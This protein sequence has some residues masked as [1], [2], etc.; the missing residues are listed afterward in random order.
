MRLRDETDLETL[1]DELVGV[2]SETMQ[3]V[4]VSLWLRSDHD[5]KSQQ[6]N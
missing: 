5:P 4:H 6:A 3:P 2:V 1:N